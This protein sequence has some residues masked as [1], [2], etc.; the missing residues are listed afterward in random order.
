[1]H[2]RGGGDSFE[3]AVA[4]GHQGGFTGN[5]LYKTLAGEGEFGITV[6]PEPGSFALLAMG[7]LGLLSLGR[8]RP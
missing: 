6:V 4:A 2:E 8:R 3:I 5:G 7:A 1:M